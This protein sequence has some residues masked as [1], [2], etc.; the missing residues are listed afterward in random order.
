MVTRIIKSTGEEIPTEPKNSKEFTLTE[1]Q[2][3][4]GGYI[5][6]VN[7]GNNQYMVVNEDGI[8][9]NLPLNHKATRLY[10]HST[11]VGDVLICKYNQIS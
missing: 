7:L 1:L 11:I 8:L 5:E 6:L 10:G 9:Q 3:I 2:E 4:V